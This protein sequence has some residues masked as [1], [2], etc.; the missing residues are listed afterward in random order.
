MPD[1]L[2][3]KGIPRYAQSR[4]THDVAWDPTSSANGRANVNQREIARTAAEVTNENE[5]V[6]IKHGFVIVSCRYRL[7]LE[8]YGLIASLLEGCSKPT[9]RITVVFLLLCSGKMNW[10]SDHR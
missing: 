5:F 2:C 9:L 7:H 10:P 4:V 3:V 6:M 8:L 1:Y